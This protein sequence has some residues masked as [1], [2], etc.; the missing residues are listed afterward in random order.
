MKKTLLVLFGGASSEYEVSLQSATAVLRAVNTELYEVVR[1]GITRFGQWLHYTGP[2]ED[3]EN[4]TWHAHPSCAPALLSPSR[5]EH[6]LWLPTLQGGAVKTIDLCLPVLHGKNGEDGTV[7]GLLQLAGIPVAGCGCRTSALCM[8]KH[9]AHALARADGIDCPRFAVLQAGLPLQELVRSTAQQLQGVPLPWY[10]KPAGEGSSFGISRIEG[11]GQLPD[12]LQNAFIYGKKV[13]VEEG[14][15]GFEVGCAI[16]GTQNPVTGAVD[17]IQL[18]GAFFDYHEKYTLETAQILLPAPLNK[19]ETARVKEVALRLYRLF[20]CSGF[21]RV[22]LFYTPNGRIIFNEINTI[23][24]MTAHSRYPGMLAAA[25]IPFEVMVARI[26][27][28]AVEA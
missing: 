23:P 4:D 7:Q 15:D 6:G 27:T 18:A 17:A 13:V 12:A 14:I 21:A 28:G 24:G 16:L 22:D 2:L 5:E 26:L 19:K 11:M 10:V 3:I 9:L 25:G 8:D 20:E 1:V